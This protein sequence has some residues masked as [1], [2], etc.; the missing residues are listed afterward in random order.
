MSAIL[1]FGV[2]SY[3]QYESGEMP[4]VSN[5]RLIQ[6]IDD[7]KKFI[8]LVGLC[9][10]L[11]S[12]TKE[13]YIENA[14]NIIADE[15]KNVFK[16]NLKEY[17]LGDHLADVYSGYRNPNFEK[18]TEMVVFFS[19]KLKPFKTKLNKLLFYADFLMY[20]ENCFSISG[21][22]YRAINMGPVPNNF[23]SIFEYLS[24]NNDIDISYVSFPQGYTGEQFIARIERPFNDSV[25]TESELIILDKIAEVF[26]DSSTSKIIETSHTE[27][28]WKSNEK[29]R[30]VISYQYA[31][32][33]TPF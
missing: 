7:P 10:S 8:E 21:I 31:F 27:E 17:L 32:E 26:K 3:R 9:E 19:E 14:Q 6:M 16:Y 29:E 15:K 11:D 25:F 20:K 18:L 12:R 1:G 13:V 24:N 23:Q 5:A 33:I 30:N 2:N 28:A 22:R 4:S